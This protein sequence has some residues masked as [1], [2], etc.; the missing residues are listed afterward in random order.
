MFGYLKFYREL[1]GTHFK[2]FKKNYCYLCRSLDKKYGVMSRLVLSY[3]T[4][5]FLCAVTDQNYLSNIKSVGCINKLSD[6]YG[7]YEY[8]D[9][10]A[11]LN[12]LLAS[13]KCEDDVLDENS[14][15]AKLVN[16]VFYIPFTKAK[17]K[18]P[19]MWNLIKERY[20]YI[21]ELEKENAS[22]N[23][24]EDYFSKF[25]IELAT[26]F[27]NLKDDNMKK[28]IY[29]ACRWLYF[30]DAFDDYEKDINKNR[31][32][33]LIFKNDSLEEKLMFFNTHMEELFS[34]IDGIKPLK[35]VNYQIVY[36]IAT[37][38][39]PLTNFKILKSK[40]KK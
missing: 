5:L 36:K 38:G 20:T 28:L 27:F 30:I 35:D 29:F 16:F 4:T 37:Q 26:E 39:I 1:G 9:K 8:T 19:K 21:R 12:L 7:D 33:P 23:E 10:I 40:R 13:A 25:M 3:D 18:H 17:R 15:K 6:H 22:L 32:N 24:I 14:L 34:L 31:F 2:Q 11:A